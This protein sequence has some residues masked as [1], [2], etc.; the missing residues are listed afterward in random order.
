MIKPEYNPPP[1]LGFSKNEPFWGE[2]M[3]AFLKW[4]WSEIAKTRLISWLWLA[5]AIIALIIVANMFRYEP[6]GEHIALRYD[7]WTNKICASSL[8]YV[9]TPEIIFCE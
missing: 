7:K 3:R 9:R 8:K 1:P 5:L 6:L 4:C 2:T